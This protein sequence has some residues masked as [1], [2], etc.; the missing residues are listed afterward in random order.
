MRAISILLASLILLLSSCGTYER[1]N[2]FDANGV[3]YNPSPAVEQ[4]ELNAGVTSLYKYSG[5]NCDRTCIATLGYLIFFVFVIMLATIDLADTLLEVVFLSK[6]AVPDLSSRPAYSFD[7]PDV[8]DVDLPNVDL[9]KLPDFS[10]DPSSYYAA[11]KDVTPSA[12]LK[13]VGMG[14]IAVEQYHIDNIATI[15]T[16]LDSLKKQL[17]GLNFDDF[18]TVG[19]S[20]QNT[21]FNTAGATLQSTAFQE[22]LSRHLDSLEIP[23]DTLVQLLNSDTCALTDYLWNARSDTFQDSVSQMLIVNLNKSKAPM[24]WIGL[25]AMYKDLYTDISSQKAG[26]IPNFLR[27][28]ALPDTSTTY[29]S[30]TAEFAQR[31][32][33]QLRTQM[34]TIE[35][36]AKKNDSGTP[37]EILQFF[38]KYRGKYQ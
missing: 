33:E 29:E 31:S 35:I 10:V 7:I 13:A 6:T 5:F 9:P 32:L 37:D 18:Q 3:A 4:Q 36:Y 11:L 2:R 8:P 25:H 22:L 17:K 26:L 21:L 16:N 14:D 28:Y 34:A 27:K 24:L 38:A 23:A 20:L 30:V 19:D 15:A 1:D 12:A